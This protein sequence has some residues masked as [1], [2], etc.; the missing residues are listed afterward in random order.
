[1]TI[2]LEQALPVIRGIEYELS[3]RGA[4]CALG[5]SV[6]HR[7]ES[8]KD[9]DIFVY[10]RNCDQQRT[11]EQLIE[12]LQHLFPTGRDLTDDAYPSDRLR[13]V[14]MHPMSA[15][16]VWKIEFFVFLN[17]A[18]TKAGEVVGAR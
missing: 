16:V 5:G 18:V 11:P 12:L 15:E 14:V 3:S 10:P 7:G 6:L 17:G 4:H 2:T 8:E 9:L 1:M 13:F